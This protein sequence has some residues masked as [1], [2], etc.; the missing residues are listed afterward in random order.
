MKKWTI[1]SAAIAAALLGCSSGDVTTTTD[2]GAI[3]AAV[4]DVATADADAGA[5]IEYMA[6]VRGE[7]ASAGDAGV[8]LAQSKAT[9]DQIAKSGEATAKAAGDIAHAVLLGTAILDGTPNEFLA[10]DR[11]TDATAMK[12]FYAN[13]QIQQAFGTLFASPP[14]IDFYVS[15][16]GWVSWGDMHSGDAYDPHY[17]HL[18]LGTLSSSDAATNEAAH[19]QVASAGQA[20]SMQAGNVAHVVWLG[21]DDA[22]QFNGVDIWSSDANIQAFYT[23]PQFVAA[24][25]SLFSSVTQPV[26]ESTDWYQ[27]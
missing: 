6:L 5:P 26:Y 4:P 1:G 23:N 27:W 16:A 20:P 9:H 7:L 10:M 25:S 2:S 17:V 12:S 3:D 13:P 18:A 11:W 19:N 14:T 24:F 8:D 22:R 15:A 21:Q